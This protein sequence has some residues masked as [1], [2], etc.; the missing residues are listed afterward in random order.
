MGAHWLPLLASVLLLP[1]LARKL[2]V[3]ENWL[4]V[5]DRWKLKLVF[6]GPLQLEYALL[7]FTRTLATLLAS[8]IALPRAMGM[9]RKTLNNRHLEQRIKQ[10]TGRITEGKSPAAALEESGF[11]PPLALRM[12]LAGERSGALQ[13]MLF[14][15]A[16]YY[17]DRVEERL[18]RLSSLIEPLMM[19]LIGLLIGGLVVAMYI[20]IFQLASAA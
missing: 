6:V 4:G 8:G 14:E 10:A 13:E 15:V 9:S 20:P 11:F 7:N 1:L 3:K 17:E 19:M 16:A 18:G 2:P 12:V 5:L